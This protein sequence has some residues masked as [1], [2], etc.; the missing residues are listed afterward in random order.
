MKQTLTLTAAALL[1]G[2]TA[3]AE[4][5]R[6]SDGSF[7]VANVFEQ[8]EQSPLWASLTGGDRDDDDDRDDRYDDRDDD[9]DDDED[10]DDDHDDD[11]D[12]DGGDD[13]G[14]DD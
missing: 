6:T 14:D 9:G 10:E 8:I 12:D 7:Q 2:T 13:D 4:T 3:I 5:D 1:L 11:R